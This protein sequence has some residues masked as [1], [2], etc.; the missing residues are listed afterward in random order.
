MFAYVRTLVGRADM[1]GHGVLRRASAPPG[2]SRKGIPCPP[3]F[4]E[5]RTACTVRLLQSCAG[6]RIRGVVRTAD[7]AEHGGSTEAGCVKE[8]WALGGGGPRWLA[9]E[10]RNGGS[11]VVP[12]ARN[13]EAW[14]LGGLAEAHVFGGLAEANL[15]GS[16]EA[17]RGRA[18]LGRRRSW[19]HVE[20]GTAV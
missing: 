7:S 11:G 9:T 5:D 12:K 2:A 17:D 14:V 13:K 6:N 3:P 18:Q 10:P 1:D 19:R 15:G 16:A 8:A 20:K 4:V